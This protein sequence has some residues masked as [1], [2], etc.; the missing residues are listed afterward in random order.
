MKNWDLLKSEVV[1]EYEVFKVRR[2]QERSPL[3]QKPFTFHVLEIPDWVQVIPITM[4][5][6][7]VMVEQFRHGIHATSLE[8]PAGVIED[9]EPAETAALRELKEET[10]FEAEGH[11]VL[12]TLYPNAALQGNKLYVVLASRCR[13]VGSRNMDEGEDLR[14]HLFEPAQV[15]AFI[16]RS[17]IT[18]THAIA[19]WAIF[20]YFSEAG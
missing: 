8:F 18:H 11:S 10:G 15:D 16:R 2:N 6:A 1:G 14:V 4:E 13:N 7:V 19:A 17:K 5:G 3:N 20:R 12:A 9:S